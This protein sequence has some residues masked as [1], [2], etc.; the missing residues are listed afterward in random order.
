MQD[1]LEVRDTQLKEM[2]EIIKLSLDTTLTMD[3]RF[4]AMF[5]SENV[6][7]ANS[8]S[9]FES[10]MISGPIS[11]SNALFSNIFKSAPEFPTNLPVN[12]TL[13]RVYEP[14][15]A[16]FGIDIATREKMNLFIRLQTVP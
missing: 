5:E 3:E 2:K 14:D 10:E 16:H 11:R 7:S 8:I 4:A 12:G 15:D 1:S 9:N 6:E 13:T